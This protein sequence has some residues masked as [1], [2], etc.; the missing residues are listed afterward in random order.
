MSTTDTS[1]TFEIYEK[2]Y[3]FIQIK[4]RQMPQCMYQR[5]ESGNK[6]K[7]KNLMIQ[8][9]FCICL[10]TVCSLFNYNWLRDLFSSLFLCCFSSA[11]F[12]RIASRW[13]SFEI[14]VFFF[15]GNRNEGKRILLV[16]NTLFTCIF[17]HIFNGLHCISLIYFGKSFFFGSS[18][19]RNILIDSIAHT[20]LLSYLN[21][22]TL[23]Y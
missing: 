2:S 4:F 9:R 22:K 8:L 15:H 7:K 20:N 5:F 1:L 18:S 16:W 17:V 23:L 11:K 10:F 3:H 6:K 19:T 14:K 21:F 12:A 13:S